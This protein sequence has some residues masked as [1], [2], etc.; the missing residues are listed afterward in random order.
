[1]EYVYSLDMRYV[2]QY[3]EV[4]VAVTREEVER[5]DV[6]NMAKGF[7]PQHNKLYGYS[8]EEQ[9]TPIELINMRL[10]CIGKTEKPEFMQDEYA[11]EDP[12]PALKK[13]R[14]VFLPRQ[15]NFANVDV[16]DGF[17]LHF[18]NRIEGPAIIEQVNTT[19]F[20]A[21]EYNVLVDKYG[22]YTMYFKEIEDQVKGRILS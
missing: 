21:S 16:F 13:K 1:V 19:T 15:K 5:G 3:H 2:K 17:E 22:S 6:E 9:G 11:G 4:S 7:H 12:S 20:V 14:R 18:G 8:L 10:V